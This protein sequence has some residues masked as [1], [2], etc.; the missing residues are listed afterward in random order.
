MGT[1]A[2][3]LR[4]LACVRGGTALFDGLS[5]GVPEGRL[6]KVSGAN[7]SGKSSLLRMICG[8]LPATRGEVLWRGSRIGERRERFHRALIYQGHAAA[9]KDELSA[10]ENLLAN[11]RLAGLDPAAE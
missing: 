8:L 1:P 3:E 9:L 7:G 11:A 2:L 6:L 4:E 5:L 10:A